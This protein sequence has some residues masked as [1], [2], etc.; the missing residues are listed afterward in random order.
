MDVIS[1]LHIV[2]I[3]LLF[4][5][6]VAS[7]ISKFMLISLLND[8]DYE[9]FKKLDGSFLLNDPFNY[10]KT[11]KH[12]SSSAS[13]ARESR[14]SRMFRYSHQ[15]FAFSIIFFLIVTVISIFSE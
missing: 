11:F 5:G 15:L 2:S 13:I 10:C 8:K 6:L 4:S 3:A 1:T 14:A 12:L 9:V 7:L